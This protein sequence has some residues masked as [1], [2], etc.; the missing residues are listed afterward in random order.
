MHAGYCGAARERQG[1]DTHRAYPATLQVDYPD[2]PL[3]RLSTLLRLFYLIP[4]GILLST[5]QNHSVTVVSNGEVVRTFATG[6]GILVLPV[7]LMLL[8][9][10]KYPGWWFDWNLE[11]ARFTMRV[12]AYGTLLNDQYPS[13][14][15]QQ[16]VHLDLQRPDTRVLSRWMPLVKWILAIPHYFCLF[17]V[18]IGVF[19]AVIVAWFAILFTGR[20]PRGIFDFVVGAH[21]WGLR[22]AA[23]TEI[24]ITDEYPPF[25]LD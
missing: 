1:M 24:L 19:F 18:F 8:F 21:R 9:R 6:G 10:R 13:T 12:A 15:E 20:Y 7:V 14:D 16:T 4:I 2:R 22:V 11:F 3:N 17:F 23:Y 5:L 25:S